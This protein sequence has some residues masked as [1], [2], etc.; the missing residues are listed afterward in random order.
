M[1]T[2]T[3]TWE[4]CADEDQRRVKTAQYWMQCADKEQQRNKL[5]QYWRSMSPYASWVSLAGW[6]HSDDILGRLSK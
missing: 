3:C 1:V 4:D 5:I 6:L 2:C